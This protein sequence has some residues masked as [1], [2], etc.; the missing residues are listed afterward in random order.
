MSIA[1]NVAAIRDRI[2]AAA[3]AAGRRPDEILLVAASKMNSADRVAEAIRA[4]V[5]ACGE[6]RVQELSEI[7]R[8]L[9]QLA[10]ELNVPVKLVGLGE[11]PDDLAPFDPHGF[12]DA[13]IGG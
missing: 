11:G 13:I 9:K 10:K 12:V 4:G 5:P 1:E 8:T 3:L 7:T 6:N 2:A